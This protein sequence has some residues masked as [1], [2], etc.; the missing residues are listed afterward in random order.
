MVTEF[1]RDEKHEGTLC[2]QQCHS[3]EVYLGDAMSYCL[4]LSYVSNSSSLLG[5]QMAYVNES[6]HLKTSQILKMCGL[7]GLSS[8]CIGYEF[9]M[10]HATLLLTFGCVT[11]DLVKNLSPARVRASDG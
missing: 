1:N 11:S 2:F 6:I 7:F 8:F 4:V 3:A 10:S 5:A 9:F